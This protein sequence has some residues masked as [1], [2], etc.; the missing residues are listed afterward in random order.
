MKL[1]LPF[2][3]LGLA[4]TQSYSASAANRFWIANASSNWNNPANW[5]N[6]SGGAGGF[7]VPG[8][9]DNVT[10]NNQG[11]G[12]CTINAAV[13]IT[14]L[15]VTAGYTGT[16]IQGANT[17][18][19]SNTADFDGGIFTGGTASM[20]VGGNFTLAGTNFTSTTVAL[21]LGGN[22][23]F[24]SGVFTHNNGTV[25]FDASGTN[26]ISSAS[27]TMNLFNVEFLALANQTYT[28]AAATT[29]VAN[30]VLTFSGTNRIRLNTGNINANGNIVLTNTATTGGGTA[31]I[32]ITGSANVVLDGTLIAAGR[33]LLPFININKTGGTLTLKGNIS[34]RRS[35][36]HTGGTV[37]ATTFNSTVIFGGGNNLTI[38]SNG[39]RF[40]NVT[41]TSNTV[42]LADNLTLNNSMVISGGILAPATNT[43]NI[44]GNWTSFGTGGFTEAT[45]TVNFNGSSTQTI[46]TTGGENFNN[47]TINNTG[48]GIQMNNNIIVEAGL[49]MTQGNVNL[50]GNTLTLGQSVANNGTL[51]YTSGTLYNTGSFTRWFKTGVIANG[52]VTGLFPVGTSTN[53]RPF[54]V[55]APVTGPTTGGTITVSYH[56]ATTNTYVP[57]YMDGAFTIVVRKDLNWAVTTANGLNGGTYNL[58][59]RGT[60]FGQVGA[61][62]D[63]RLTLANTVVGTA[64]VN[65]GTTANPQINRTGLSRANLVNTFY[66]GSTNLV[67]SPLPITLVSF[68]ASVYNNAVI[69]YWIT[70]A[71]VNNDHFTIQRSRDGNDGWE[72]LGNIPGKL[73]SSTDQSYSFRDENPYSGVSYYRLKQTDI[74]GDVSYS[75]VVPVKIGM[76]SSAIT[77][78]PNPATDHVD[79]RFAEEGRYEVSVVSVAGQL[80]TAPVVTIGTGATLNVSALKSGIYFIQILHEGRTETRKIMIRK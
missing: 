67:S 61:V 20:T 44:A 76:P 19:I 15:T 77:V 49:T 31:T 40:N 46:S 23:S 65:A 47:L 52:S 18:A 8:V 80:M 48:T 54:Y 21:A 27:G 64:G 57:T 68:T 41:V 38:T 45:S 25:R 30:G 72:D 2:L 32:N 42:T 36:T 34:A 43:I 6:V 60:G 69:L 73:N 16:I 71:E 12:N 51:T 9:N 11:R 26:T 29:I 56:D 28:I 33:N 37:D 14:S 50:N 63:L 13:N 58:D 39:M 62:S 53:Y 74:D 70:S 75:F 4:L 17:I 1:V 78:Y 5:S 24:T 55:S 66:I 79:I 3:V 7:S 59:V 10:F 22:V 35:W